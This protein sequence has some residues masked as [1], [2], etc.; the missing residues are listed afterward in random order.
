MNIIREQDSI[1]YQIAERQLAMKD[2]S[3][4]SWFNYVKLVLSKYNMPSIYSLL[5]NDISNTEWKTLTNQSI[6]SYVEEQWKKETLSKSSL[7]Y[8]NPDNLKV[9]QNHPVWSTVRCN[10][11]DNKRAQLKCKLLT[12]TYLLQGNRAVFNQYAVD[13]TC[14][15]CNNAPETRQHLIAE[16][17]VYATERNDLTGKLLNNPVLPASVR[18]SVKNPEILTQLMLDGSAVVK[19]CDSYVDVLDYLELQSRDFI[20]KIHQKRIA[21]LKLIA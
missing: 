16:C 5:E 18:D 19:G 2:I 12:G 3:E 14:K 11:M 10:V 1:E 13:P 17:Q 9:G 6:N 15:L 20:Y 7:K 21:R 8:V 4:K